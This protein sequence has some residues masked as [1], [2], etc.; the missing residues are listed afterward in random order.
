MKYNNKNENIEVDDM[1]IKSHL[2][3]SLDLSGISVSEDLINRT[4]E[5]IKKQTAQQQ[6]T[7]VSQTSMEEEH[8][9]V[10]P[11]N[12][13]IRTFAGVAAAA[14]VIVAGYGIINS[15]MMGSK[16][17]ASTNDT[18]SMD[19]A[20]ETTA[21]DST[22]STADATAT[23]DITATT[24]TATE[25]AAVTNEQENA[26]SAQD[27]NSEEALQ[28]TITAD[29]GMAAADAEEGATGS[30]GDTTVG[31]TAP[32]LKGAVSESPL[33]FRDIFPAEP[34]QV[35]SI[36]VTD[37][38]N[39]SSFTLTLQEDILDFY[40]VMDQQQFTYST[41]TAAEA[42][43]TIEITTAPEEALYSMTIG[44]HIT[45][46]YS[47]GGVSSQSLYDAVDMEALKQSLIDLLTKYSR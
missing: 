12:R 26:L 45:V 30:V 7:E 31:A 36:T 2:N 42:A 1:K 21:A 25:E 44:D 5:A 29:T 28:F 33:A 11:W 13:Y 41:E 35:N 9:K 19:M 6:I 47:G 20:Y 10:I 22:M 37:L 43:Y 40:T 34:T 46:N 15:G 8:K 14:I 38:V 4:L 23:Q 39:V 18:A 3:A 32:M 17:S 24:D 27:D 16:K